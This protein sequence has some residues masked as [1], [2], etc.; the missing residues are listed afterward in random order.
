VTS[1]FS[2][3]QRKKKRGNSPFCFRRSGKGQRVRGDVRLRHC[4]GR[5]ASDLHVVEREGSDRR[6]A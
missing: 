1:A 4:R 6:S 5:P 2:Q 3:L